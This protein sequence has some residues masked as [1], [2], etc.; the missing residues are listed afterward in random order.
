MTNILEKIITDKKDS[1]KKY[2]DSFAI[3]YLN[4]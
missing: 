3:E 1:I 4:K 2:K